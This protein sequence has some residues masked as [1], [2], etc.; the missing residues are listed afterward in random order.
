MHGFL[1]TPLSPC[2]CV[3]VCVCVCARVVV[4]SRPCDIMGTLVRF[5]I[6]VLGAKRFEWFN[7]GS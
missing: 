1:P 2:V 3:C 6:A 4:Q 7:T 5:V